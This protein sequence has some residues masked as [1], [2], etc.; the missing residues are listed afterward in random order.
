MADDVIH[1]PVDTRQICS[2]FQIFRFAGQ[3][4]GPPG[5]M[6]H[7][8]QR[9]ALFELLELFLEVR[10]VRF[11]DAVLD[12]MGGSAAHGKKLPAIE[13]IYLTSHEVQNGGTYPLDLSTMPFFFGV[14]FVSV[15]VFVVPK[16]KCSSVW[17]VLQ[18]VQSCIIPWVTVP[19]STKISTDQN[20]ILLGQVF[21]LIEDV[22]LL[23]SILAHGLLDLYITVSEFDSNC[24][25][26]DYGDPL[27]QLPNNPVIILLEATE[28]FLQVSC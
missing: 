8:K 17:P 2:G 11:Q 23:V 24:F 14:V 16:H 21:L 5:M 6:V 3:F 13:L 26:V 1:I 20:Q 18:P 27:N 19:D 4:L 10:I 25:R 9:T 28:V 12:I 7:T 15:I 22:L